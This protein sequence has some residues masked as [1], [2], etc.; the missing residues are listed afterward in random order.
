[1][2]NEIIMTAIFSSNFIDLSSLLRT[3]LNISELFE[4]EAHTASELISVRISTL[5]RLAIMTKIHM[6]VVTTI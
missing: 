1:M 5:M 2:V 4:K 3:I 6:A